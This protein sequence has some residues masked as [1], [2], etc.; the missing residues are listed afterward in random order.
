MPS[1]CNS[2]ERKLRLLTRFGRFEFRV[3]EDEIEIDT[4]LKLSN[5]FFSNKRSLFI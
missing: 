2:W 1:S 5:F 3:F 4:D